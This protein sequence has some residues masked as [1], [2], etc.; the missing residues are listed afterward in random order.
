MKLRVL[1]G[2]ECEGAIVVAGCIEQELWAIVDADESDS[3]FAEMKSKYIDVENWREVLVEVPD[4]E[5][6]AVFQVT[7]IDGSV[8]DG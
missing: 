7:E 6:K 2:Q 4:E 3:W 8:V 5:L 1:V